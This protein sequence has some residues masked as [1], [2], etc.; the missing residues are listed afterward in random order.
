LPEP[1]NPV[2]TLEERMLAIDGRVL[3]VDQAVDL[4][5]SVGNGVLDSLDV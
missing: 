3:T 1:C 2:R 5:Y 4:A